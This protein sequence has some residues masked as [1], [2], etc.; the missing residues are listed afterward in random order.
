MEIE[1]GILHEV[2]RYMKSYELTELER[3][4][5]ISFHEMKIKRQYDYDRT[6]DTILKPFN[7]VQDIMVRGISGTWKQPVFYNY[8]FDYSCNI[9]ENYIK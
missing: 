7:Y 9:L 6:S 8:E 5:V 3:L 4:C 1:P 2:L